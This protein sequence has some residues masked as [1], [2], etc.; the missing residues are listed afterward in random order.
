M[1]REGIHGDGFTMSSVMSSLSDGG[2][3]QVHGLAL[4]SGLDVY[5]SVGNALISCYSGR[6]MLLEAEQIFEGM[7]NG[8]RDGVS[9][10]C[11]IVA[12]GQHH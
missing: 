5:V 7:G 1:R 4:V 6:G 12:Y 11:M 2:V 9:W 3:E 8:G 10:N